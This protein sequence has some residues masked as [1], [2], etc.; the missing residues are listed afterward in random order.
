MNTPP[1]Q[2]SH[3]RLDGS[4]GLLNR[5]TISWLSGSGIREMYWAQ[6]DRF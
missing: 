4:G 2:G 5:S 1:V 6:V 3:A